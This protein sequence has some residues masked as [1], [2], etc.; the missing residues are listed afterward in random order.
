MTAATGI[1]ARVHLVGIGGMHMSAIARILLAWGH[2][3]SGSDQRRTPLVDAIEA[4]GAKVHIDARRRQRRRRRPRRDNVGRDRGQPGAGR[5]AAARHPRDQARGHGREADGGQAGVVRRR[6]PRQEHDQRPHRLHPRPR[7]QGPH[8]PDRRRGRGPG[9]ER[10]P[11]R[12]P[13]RRRR[14]RRVRPRLPQ[15]HARDGAGH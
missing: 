11:R 1:P 15:L 8:L 5:S 7:R 10:R 12:R 3:V 2:E 6:Q 4:L 14:G 13:A 9:H